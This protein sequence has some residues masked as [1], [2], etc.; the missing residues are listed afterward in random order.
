M[1]M[2]VMNARKHDDLVTT[3]NRHKYEVT[4]ATEKEFVGLRLSA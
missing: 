2:A 1:L 4:D 3:F